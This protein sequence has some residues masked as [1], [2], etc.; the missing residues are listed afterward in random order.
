MKTAVYLD[1]AATTRLHPKAL[2]AMLPFLRDAYGNPSGNYALGRQAARA[3]DE[4]R[5]TVAGVLNCRP[6]ETVFTGPGTESI[7]AAVKGVAF[8]QRQ[9]G[10]GNHIV[11]TTLEHHAVLHS[12]EYLEEFGFEITYVPVDAYGMVDPDG[13]ARAVNERTVLVS[14]ML[15]NNEIG[16]VQPIARIVE[17]VRERA[18]SLP[19]ARRRVPVH[20]DAVQGANALDLDVAKLGVDLLSLSAHKFSG[21]KGAGVLYVKRGTPFLSQLSGGGQERQRRAGTEN[22]A[23]IAATAVALREAQQ[24]RESYRAVCGAL[25]RRLAEGVLRA[26]PAAT[27]NGHREQRL[28]NNA[29]FSFEGAESDGI[30]SAL[31]KLGIA[32]SAGSACNSATWEPSHVLVAIGMPLRRAAGALRLT[33]GPENTEE[34]IDYVLSVLPGAVAESRASARHGLSA[35]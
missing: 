10:L 1:H 24:G 26:V 16:T 6:Q 20:T 34:E 21:P 8:A 4:A 30:L 2:E 3:I 9:A 25:T 14:V 7:N 22:V 23:S 18:K 31:D 35:K 27:F 17:A 32:A 15:A 11:T 33:A 13:V 29:H 28:P 12:C 19:G 5:S